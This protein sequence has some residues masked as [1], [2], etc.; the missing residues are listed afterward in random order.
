MGRPLPTIVKLPFVPASA[1]WV[2]PRRRRLRHTRL[3]HV[4]H[5]ALDVTLCGRVRPGDEVVERP[6]EFSLC[7]RCIY[8]A[9]LLW[10][11]I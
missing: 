7:P 4:A 10:D 8:R 1:H 5:R 9:G 2:L 6:P 3:V 11:R